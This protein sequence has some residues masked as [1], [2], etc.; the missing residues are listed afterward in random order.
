V[1]VLF[2]AFGMGMGHAGRMLAVSD[3][4]REK[5]VDIV[6]STFG[7]AYN[8][9]KQMGYE[10][11]KLPE[12]TFEENSDGGIDFGKTV[13][14]SPKLVYNLTSQVIT[15]RRMLK[16][17]NPDLVISDSDFSI[18]PQSKLLGIKTFHLIHQHKIS[19]PKISFRFGKEVV[20]DLQHI[21]SKMCDKIIVP[22]IGPPNTL[23]QRILPLS[24]KIENKVFFSGLIVRHSRK[25]KKIKL[26]E[27][28]P[29]VFVTVSGPGNSKMEL[30][31]Y[32]ESVLPALKD[33]FF[34]LSK[35]TPG[36][37]VIKRSKNMIIFNWIPDDVR[38][39]LMMHSDV[40]VSRSG[41]STVSEIMWYGKK[42]VLTP[43][44]NQTEQEFISK[45]LDN[46]GL[47]KE[48]LQKDIA[49]FPRILDDVV[50]DKKM[51]KKV[52]AYG[53]LVR[54]KDGAVEI[55][56]LILNELDK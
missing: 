49:F 23:Y 29:I 45:N 33:K 5:G 22:D 37:N 52:A 34:V 35:G 15:H 6:Y 32:Y 4:L 56:N 47:A 30:L 1:K 21:L 8:F 16:K 38:N 51:K 31:K 17:T 20:V 25:I 36:G 26:P 42:S 3:I 53:K 55:A 39:Y 54:K 27:N 18:L 46:R 40:I 9:L 7:P 48:M 2:S 19:V 41:F 11:Y 43:I 13:I 28:K 44:P 24:K 12:I 50:N 14:K 10:V